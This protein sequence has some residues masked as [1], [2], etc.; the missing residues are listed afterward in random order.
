VLESLDPL[1]GLMAQVLDLRGGEKV[2]ELLVA[3][4]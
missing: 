4:A 2:E 1:P 3:K